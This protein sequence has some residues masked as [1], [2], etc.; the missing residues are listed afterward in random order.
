[1]AGLFTTSGDVLG[2]AREIESEQDRDQRHRDHEHRHHVGHRPLARPHQL[3]EH[4]QD[5]GWRELYRLFGY[6]L[7]R[8]RG[9]DVGD[10]TTVRIGG[11][12]HRIEI[13]GI[14]REF[15]NLGQM[16]TM[17]AE[18]L[19]R[20]DPDAAAGIYV[21]QLEEGVQPAA[22]AADIQGEAGGLLGTARLDRSALPKTLRD[23]QGVILALSGV[24][25]LTVA[26][27][28][29]SSVSLSVA[30]RRREMGVLKA[31]G[32]SR[33]RLSGRRRLRSISLT[34]TS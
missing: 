5:H 7:A 22:F 2:V 26:V 28:I 10:T 32:M 31:V 30:E 25:V 15:N 12:D 21:V 9:L 3:G 23:V 1:M 33:C 11:G 14:V 18:T 8:D 24:M 17:P 4:P 16:L 20:F 29:L 34:G 19:R 13:T 27:G 6:G